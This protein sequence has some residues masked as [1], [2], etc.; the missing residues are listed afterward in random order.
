MKVCVFGAG[1]IGC[2]VGGRLAATGS[3]VS[4]VGRRSV[5]NDVTEHGLR[6]TDLHGGSWSVPADS[7]AM[8]TD[9]SEVGRADLILVTVKSGATDE[10]GAAIAEYVRPGTLVISL[11]NG[12]GNDDRLRQL[13]PECVVLP[14]MVMFNIVRRGPG[15][16]HQG[17]DGTV[18]VRDDPGLDQCAPLFT[19]AGL[20]LT[21]HTDLRPVQWAKLLL[22]LNNPVNALAGIPL[23]QELAQRSFRRCLASAQREA[24]DVMTRAGIRPARLTAIPPQLMC[25]VLTVPDAVFS[26][27]AG[28]VLA[29]NPHARSSMLD[30]LDAGRTTEIDWLSGEVVRLATE[31]GVA[32][33]VNQRLLELIRDAESGNWT[34]WAG[35][36]LLGELR[37]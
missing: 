3:D 1:S 14:G 24:L 10:A 36:D 31:V 18:E 20:E 19:S 35:D 6:L 34:K 11:Q 33:P 21:R 30:D 29:V 8:T 22:N 15:H 26:R 16:F 5:M 2:Y 4:F 7:V 17:S 9:P 28:R 32:A 37:R 13:L 27:V 25:R 12:L 23:K